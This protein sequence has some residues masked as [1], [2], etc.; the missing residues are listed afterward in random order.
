MQGFILNS[1]YNCIILD[2][3]TR[4]KQLQQAKPET[5]NYCYYL[6]DLPIRHIFDAVRH[7][8]TYLFSFKF[9]F[10]RVHTGQSLDRKINPH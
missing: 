5:S 8:F 1:C 9:L 2:I 4:T 10:L 7:R 3:K 6:I